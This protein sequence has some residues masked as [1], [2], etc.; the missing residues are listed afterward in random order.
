MLTS[1]SKK[2]ERSKHE[3]I[4]INWNALIRVG[5]PEFLCSASFGC[6]HEKSFRLQQEKK[7]TKF[8]KHELYEK[9]KLRWLFFEKNKY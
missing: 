2:P 5:D 9:E 1:F 6:Y 4:P 3:D 8:L 7:N